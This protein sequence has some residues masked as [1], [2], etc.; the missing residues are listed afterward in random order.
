MK[1]TKMQMYP[2]GFPRTFQK[3]LEPS[4]QFNYQEDEDV[5]PEPAKKIWNVPK[6]LNYEENKQGRKNKRVPGTF[7][8]ALEPSKRLWN[9]DCKSMPNFFVA[10][11]APT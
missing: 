5:S 6:K 4:K 11:K 3:P 8:K 9:L 1:Q 2:E 10:L 7:S